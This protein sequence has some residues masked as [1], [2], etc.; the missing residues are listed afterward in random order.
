MK[1]TLA[2]FG[3]MAFISPEKKVLLQYTTTSPR[4]HQLLGVGTQEKVSV[5][6]K[7]FSVFPKSRKKHAII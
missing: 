4:L 2:A 3:A 1:A 6:F 5:R 7:K